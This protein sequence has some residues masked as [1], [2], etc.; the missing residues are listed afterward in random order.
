MNPTAAVMDKGIPRSQRARI[1]PVKANGMPVNT[2][3]PS[4]TFPNIANS[5]T[6]TKSSATGTTIC[7][8]FVADSS[9]SKVPPQAVQYPVGTVICSAIAVSASPTNEPRSLPRTL[10]L[11]TIL[12]LPSSRDTWLGPGAKSN[13]A[14]SDNGMYAV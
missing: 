9:C 11:T 14:T 8:R 6:N 10:S 3:S 5:S 12:R 13:V 2:S 4:L 7:R 1:P